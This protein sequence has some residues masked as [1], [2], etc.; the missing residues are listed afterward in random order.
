MQAQ[1]NVLFS[2]KIEEYE[3]AFNLVDT[4]KKGEIFFMR[5]L[6]H[7]AL[8]FSEGHVIKSYLTRPLGHCYPSKLTLCPTCN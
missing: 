5:R 8:R 6:Q 1:D 7:I 3:A 4:D 2:G